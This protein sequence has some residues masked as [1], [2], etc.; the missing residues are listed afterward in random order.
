M[1]KT[2]W[3]C[4]CWALSP[5]PHQPPLKATFLLLCDCPRTAWRISGVTTHS[6]TLVLLV[7]KLQFCSVIT[8]HTVTT[9]TRATPH[10]VQI[11]FSPLSP[12]SGQGKPAWFLWRGGRR[13]ENHLYQRWD[14]LY[15]S[16]HHIPPTLVSPPGRNTIGSSIP[17]RRFRSL[18]WLRVRPVRR[19]RTEKIWVRGGF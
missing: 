2:I 19:I 6:L 9:N 1:T 10:N 3:P 15:R 14:L 11:L 5:E 18:S 13:G 8:S 12:G 7:R 4:W 16:Q 17:G